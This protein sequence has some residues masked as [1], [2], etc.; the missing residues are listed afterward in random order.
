MKKKIKS[1]KRDYNAHS[2]HALSYFSFV[3]FVAYEHQYGY[4]PTPLSLSLC[5]AVAT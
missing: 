1:I 2:N 4:I 5:H 3:G